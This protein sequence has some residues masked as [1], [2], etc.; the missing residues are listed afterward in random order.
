MI[1]FI[2]WG[3]GIRKWPSLYELCASFLTRKCY[4]NGGQIALLLPVFVLHF[5]SSDSSLKMY[6]W[7]LVGGTFCVSVCLNKP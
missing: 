4:A 1:I 6:W 3:T 2:K 5:L 7:W